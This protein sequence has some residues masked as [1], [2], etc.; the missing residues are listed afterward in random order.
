MIV[1]NVIDQLPNALEQMS[2]IKEIIN[3][4]KPALFLDYD[5]TLAPIVA[6]PEDALL[7]EGTKAIIKQLADSIPVIIL[8]G[9]DRS[10]VEQKVG[11]EQLVYAGSHGFDITGPGFEKMQYSGGE[12]ALPALEQAEQELREKLKDIKGV[13]VER[14]RYA[15]A[16]HYRNVATEEIPIVKEVVECEAE[17]QQALKNG[18]GKKIVELKPAIDWHKGK[19]LL[20]LIEELNLTAENYVPIFIGDDITDEDALLAVEKRG[21]GII[22]GSHG[23]ETAASYKFDTLEEVTAFLK[24]LLKFL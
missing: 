20:W 19:A 17:K 15:I 3:G 4:R 21:I 23:G 6:K 7:P 13:Q 22:V 16:V 2:Q 5:G 11:L 24:K 10:D 8:S 18:I 14:K 12:K 1:K 9:R